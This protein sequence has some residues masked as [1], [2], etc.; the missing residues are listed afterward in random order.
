MPTETFHL[1]DPTK[2]TAFLDE[3]TAVAIKHQIG[4]SGTTFMFAMEADDQERKFRADD[5]DGVEFV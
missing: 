5:D 3:L 1:P 4:L 2:V